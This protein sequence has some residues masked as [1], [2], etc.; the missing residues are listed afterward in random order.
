MFHVT[1][2]PIVENGKV[3][4]CSTVFR[5]KQGSPREA[6]L[7][8]RV[9]KSVEEDLRTGVRWAQAAEYVARIM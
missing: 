4:P 8:E 7:E 9:L 6:V 2:R 3:R 1:D 5:R